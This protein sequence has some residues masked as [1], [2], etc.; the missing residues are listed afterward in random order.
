MS[1]WLVTLAIAVVAMPEPS[2]AAAIS[3][4]SAGLAGSL[5]AGAALG[6]PASG[7]PGGSGGARAQG[8]RVAHAH[9]T[10][11]TSKALPSRANGPARVAR[12][13]AT[14]ELEPGAIVVST[15]RKLVR[16]ALGRV[17]GL[18]WIVTIGPRVVI[19]FAARPGGHADT[20]VA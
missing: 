19:G 2:V 20:I 17:D 12:L 11:T 7:G 9:R 13:P 15:P 1:R 10:V 14:I 3:A 16:H 6:S 18:S 4:G 8:L 5:R